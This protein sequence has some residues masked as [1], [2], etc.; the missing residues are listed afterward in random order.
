M[1]VGTDREDDDTHQT[2]LVAYVI[3]QY[4]RQ[5]VTKLKPKFAM[6]LHGVASVYN[7]E[8]NYFQIADDIEKI[9]ED[10]LDILV[11]IDFSRHKNRQQQQKQRQAAPE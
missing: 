7:F 9:T 11:G 1:Y 3:L 2:K 6:K 10:T 4:D 8:K 5:V